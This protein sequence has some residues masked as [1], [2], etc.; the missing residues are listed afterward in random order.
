MLAGLLQIFCHSVAPST[1]AMASAWLSCVSASSRA[2]V[3][4]AVFD[5]IMMLA[6]NVPDVHGRPLRIELNDL[7][8]AIKNLIVEVNVL[9]KDKVIQY[10][11]ESRNWTCQC[12][13]HGPGGH[14]WLCSNAPRTRG[15]RPDRQGRRQAS[16]IQTDVTGSAGWPRALRRPSAWTH[17][18]LVTT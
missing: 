4:L 14:R 16:A 15:L 9:L 1:R 5:G 12:T 17:R 6:G 7:L 3:A 11:S 13:G 8:N 2:R 18:Y 10:R